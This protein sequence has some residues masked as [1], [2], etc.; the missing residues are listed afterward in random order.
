MRYIVNLHTFRKKVITK[1]VR[2]KNIEHALNKQ[3]KLNIF[4]SYCEISLFNYKHTGLFKPLLE[5][6]NKSQFKQF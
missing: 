4:C 3:I 5:K 2:S 6:L 1:I